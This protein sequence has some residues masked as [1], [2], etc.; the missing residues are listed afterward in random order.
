MGPMV[1]STSLHEHP[2][3][4]PKEAADLRQRAYSPGTSFSFAADNRCPTAKHWTRG[5][6]STA[7]ESPV[8]TDGP[9]MLYFKAA[10]RLM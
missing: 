9:V 7:V 3:Y 5:S 1:W 4:D 2:D 10:T 6:K 8:A